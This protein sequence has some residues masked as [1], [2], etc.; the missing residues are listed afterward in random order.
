MSLLRLLS[1]RDTRVSGTIILLAAVLAVLGCYLL[2]L[3]RAAAQRATQEQYDQDGQGTPAP[4]QVR[5]PSER[6][7]LCHATGN[8]GYV[9][10]TVDRNSTAYQGHLGHPN[11][12]IPAPPGGCPSGPTPEPTPTPTPEPTTVTPT[13]TATATATATGGETTDDGGCPVP[14][15]TTVSPTATATATDEPTPTP[16]PTAP[17]PTTTEPTATATASP[18]ATAGGQT[19]ASPTATATDEPTQTATQTGTASPGFTPTPTAIATKPGEDPAG[20]AEAT[21]PNGEV[22]TITLY[23]LDVDDAPPLPGGPGGI[24]RSEILGQRA[25]AEALLAGEDFHGAVDAAQPF[26][27]ACDSRDAVRLA[28][29]Q[30]GIPLPETGGPAALG[31]IAAALLLGSGLFAWRLVQR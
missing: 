13:A 28:A 3:D 14:E 5:A 9:T 21:D 15:P 11:D 26:L 2:G 17:E 19:T 31:L 25:A 16:E 7:T 6:V 4:D 22:T 1:S 12:I 29:V 30:L 27:N 8:G 18:T 20:E 24:T 10:I 23:D